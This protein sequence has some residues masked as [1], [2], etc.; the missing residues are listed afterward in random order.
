MTLHHSRLG[1]QPLRNGTD[2]KQPRRTGS[3]FLHSSQSRHDIGK[4]TLEH[5]D[6]RIEH[7]GILPKYGK[8]R[9]SIQLN[10]RCKARLLL[11]EQAYKVHSSIVQRAVVYMVANSMLVE[12][13]EYIDSGSGSFLGVCLFAAIEVRSE[14]GREG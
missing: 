9:Q 1:S 11:H 3:I 4:G 6:R 8:A 2:K 13:E 12:G 5:G 14:F 10:R 7:T